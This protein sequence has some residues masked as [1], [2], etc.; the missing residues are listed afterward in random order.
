MGSDAEAPYAPQ[1]A[2]VWEEREKSSDFEGDWGHLFAFGDLISLAKRRPRQVL[3]K[4]R[5]LGKVSHGRIDRLLMDFLRDGGAVASTALKK[6]IRAT[7][8][9][10]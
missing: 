5:Q 3:C 6:R 10:F 1:R 9:G 4:S 2:V 8:S 7:V